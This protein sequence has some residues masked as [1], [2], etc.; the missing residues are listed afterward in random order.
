MKTV[1]LFTEYFPFGNRTEHVFLQNE[2]KYLQDK[3]DKL[4]VFPSSILSELT[5]YKDLEVND[6]LARA[7]KLK[8]N[9]CILWSP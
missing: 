6:T 3:F 8:K 5:Y 2:I 7:L 4:I 9:A 1:L